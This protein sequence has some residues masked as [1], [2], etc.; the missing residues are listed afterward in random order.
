MFVLA[1][2]SDSP[3]MFDVDVVLF[4][5]LTGWSTMPPIQFDWDWLGEYRMF[6]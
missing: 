4:S 3:G 2:R 1:A 5:V 6:K